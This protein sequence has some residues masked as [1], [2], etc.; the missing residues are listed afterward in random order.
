MRPMDPHQIGRCLK[1]NAALLL[2]AGSLFAA[3]GGA[4]D[5]VERAPR[6][7]AARQHCGAQVRRMFVDKGVPY[8]PPAV[9]VRIFKREDRLELW[10]GRRDEALTL[11]K[12][13]KVCAKSGV[14]G[15]K[16]RVGDM[17]VPEGFYGI[18]QFNPASRFHLSLRVDYP[19]ASDRV[20]GDRHRPGG[21]IFIHGSCV[22]IGCV[23]IENGPIE[24][25]FLA[26][27]DSRLAGNR[28]I[29]VH[30]FPTRMDEEGMAF[31][32]RAFDRHM[33]FWRNLRPGF[34]A[35]EQTRKVPQLRVDPKTGAY[36]VTAAE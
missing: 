5:A 12:S 7:V 14:L 19:N 15:P 36:R 29:P 13:Y 31:L 32:Q 28:E 10:A 16:R 9:F 34:I 17:Q 1:A 6:V 24:E 25:L 4:A 18:T 26:L 33:E 30:I 23:P 35:F 27:L 8:P 11:I 3:V 22:T 2:S 21:D 20:L